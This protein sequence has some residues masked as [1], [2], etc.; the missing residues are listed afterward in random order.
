MS[1]LTQKAM[2]DAVSELLKTRTL[3][4]ISI[5]DITDACGLTRNTFYYHFHDV[6]D[7]LRWL[8]EE[9]TRQIMERYRDN[10][11]WEGG[12]EEIL[13]YFYEN[14]MMILHIYESI[15]GDLLFRF[16]NDVMYQHAEVIV[17]Q[18]AKGHGSTDGAIRIAALFYMNAIVG[19]VLQWLQAGMDRS[20]E[21][22]AQQYN[23]MFLGTVKA[24][25]DSSEEAAK[26]E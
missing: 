26:I 10:A 3:D 12:L 7:L 4:R 6:Y 19:D 16:V 23:T 24:V 18:Q 11:D 9:K 1:N 20:P 25:L 8:F 15:N 17:A 2:A 21:K 5:R 14:R 13:D 22:M